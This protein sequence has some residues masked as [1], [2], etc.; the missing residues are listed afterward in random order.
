MC[1]S[2]CGQVQAYRW[3]ACV[4]QFER[5]LVPSSVTQSS[6]GSGLYW[7]ALS[8]SSACWIPVIDGS[9]ELIQVTSQSPLL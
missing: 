7:Q 5:A 6:F 2:V 3:R 9:S 1:K 4:L 8:L